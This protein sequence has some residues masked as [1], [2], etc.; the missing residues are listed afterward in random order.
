M[1]NTEDEPVIEF[2]RNKVPMQK[3]KAIFQRER[4][5]R[6]RDYILILFILAFSRRLLYHRTYER[7][8]YKHFTYLKP[9][10]REGVELCT[11]SIIFPTIE[12]GTRLSNVLP[13]LMSCEA[14]IPNRWFTSRFLLRYFSLIKNIFNNQS[15][16]YRTHKL[17]VVSKRPLHI[18]EFYSTGPP[19][20]RPILRFLTN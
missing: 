7:D 17:T 9:N 8:T 2:K 15:S 13:T 19:G 6:S 11:S 12:N 1:S 16:Q 20:N 10:P 3:R 5:R 4:A 18:S 14:I